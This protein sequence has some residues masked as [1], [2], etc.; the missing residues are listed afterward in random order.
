MNFRKENRG[1]V[2][3][4]VTQRAGSTENAEPENGGPKNEQ[5]AGKSRTKNARP[6]VTRWNLQ[7]KKMQ[8]QNSVGRKCRTGKCRISSIV[9]FPNAT[10]VRI[11]CYLCTT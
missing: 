3:K 2:T 10:Q 7:E 9:A 1:N 5:N 11:G 8:N 4:C 6:P